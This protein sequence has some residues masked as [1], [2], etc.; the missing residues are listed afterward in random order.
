MTTPGPYRSSGTISPSQ[1][2][3]LAPFA[4]SPW[5]S[6]AP[7][8]AGSPAMPLGAMHMGWQEEGQSSSCGLL[9]W[10]PMVA[11]FMAQFSPTHPVNPFLWP[12]QC[13]NLAFGKYGHQKPN[14]THPPIV[15]DV[16]PGYRHP[17]KSSGHQMPFATSGSILDPTSMWAVC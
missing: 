3:K 9:V 1:H 15:V 12:G 4:K 6:T 14:G 16:T 5:E 2:P 7:I 11:V 8:P 13:T 17:L 10:P